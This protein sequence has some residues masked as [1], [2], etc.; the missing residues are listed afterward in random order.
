MIKYRSKKI[1]MYFVNKQ[2]IKSINHHIILHMNLR[3]ILYDKKLQ[4]A[5]I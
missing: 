4:I 5:D 3:G 1:N 2:R